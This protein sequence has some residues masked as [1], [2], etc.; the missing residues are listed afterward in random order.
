MSNIVFRRFVVAS[1]LTNLADGVAT[2]A[3][4][5]LAS[6]LTRDPVLITLV[7]V[8]LRL[9]W[10]VFAIPAGIITDRVDRRKLILVMDVVRAACFLVA[11]LAIWKSLPF[12]AAPKTGVSNLPLYLLMIF[13]ALLVGLAEVF[14][15]NASQTMLPSIVPHKEL[16]V[17]NGRLWSVEL[18]AN[19][20]LGP[21]IGAFLIAWALPIP[22]AFNTIAYI[23]AVILIIRLKGL[24][25]PNTNVNPNWRKELREGF[26]FLGRVKLL[27]T[28]AWLTGFWNLFFQMAFIALVLH[29]QENLNFDARIYGLVLAAGAIGGVLGGWLGA[30]IIKKLGSRK[31]TQLTLTA[32]APAFLLM[33]IA[34]G[35]VTL[36]L[37]L[38]V[39]EFTGIIW[40][41]VSVSYRQRIIPDHLLGRV[42][43]IYRL[44][45]WGMMP[46]G[47][48][49]S[50]LLV[51]FGEEYFSREISLSLPFVGAAL[52]TSILALVGWRAISKGFDEVE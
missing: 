18:L 34:P 15:D 6:L 16:E 7:A 50:G 24:F 14:R 30:P 49:F 25:R 9:P 33:G 23:L 43:S 27:R 29:V 13:A 46:V 37:T 39:F 2:V 17:A 1:G 47:L 21:A 36:G 26:E 11:S 19:A 12:D 10:F 22:F 44:L 45:A 41:T 48:L 28:F 42:N 3:W 8:A 32:S 38:A 4:A 52:G 5:W 20:M 40:N 51:R 35:P 31:S